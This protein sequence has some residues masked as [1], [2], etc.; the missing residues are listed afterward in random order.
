MPQQLTRLG[1]EIEW[2]PLP[3]GDFAIGHTLLVE[4]KAVID[5]HGAVIGG[6]YWSQ[7]GR[8]RV[9]CL[10]PYL[11]VEG[12]DLDRGPLARTRFE[13]CLVATLGLGV[14]LISS[15]GAADT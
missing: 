15:R 3:V 6:R 14:R 5:L 13:G 1:V 4:R 9:S 11:I 2:A 8:L 12:S 10:D 7:V